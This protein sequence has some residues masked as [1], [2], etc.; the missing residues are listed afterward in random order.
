MLD[1]GTEGTR[2]ESSFK[3]K[4]ILSSSC[5]AVIVVLCRQISET[6]N[7]M[8]HQDWSNCSVYEQNYVKTGLL[9]L[10]GRYM[11]VCDLDMTNTTDGK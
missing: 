3:Q 6:Y 1:Y 11:G 7:F 4:C 2:F 10:S 9:V 5:V 8:R